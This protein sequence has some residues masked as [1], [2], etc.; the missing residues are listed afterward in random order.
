[1]KKFIIVLIF[2]FIFSSKLFSFEGDFPIKYEEG[3][4]RYSFSGITDIAYRG[5]FFYGIN[6]L[7]NIHNYTPLGLFFHGP[8]LGFENNF[9]G[10]NI[11]GFKFGYS[12]DYCT[13]FTLKLNTIFY[14]NHELWDLRIM[15]EIGLT[16]FMALG[17]TYGYSIPCFDTIIHCCPVKS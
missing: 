4:I 9:K 5:Q 14:K 11:S 17:L 3:M 7:F 1:M 10:N 15:P 16:L 8:I 2:V 13:F 12:L 6:I